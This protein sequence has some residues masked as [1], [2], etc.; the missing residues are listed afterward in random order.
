MFGFNGEEEEDEEEEGYDAGRGDGYTE[1]ADDLNRDIN[2]PQG[3]DVSILGD[4]ML[5]A[6]QPSMSTSYQHVAPSSSIY[7]SDTSMSRPLYTFM[8]S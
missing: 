4:P 3:D 7:S 1:L 5:Y 6:D 2:L 8:C